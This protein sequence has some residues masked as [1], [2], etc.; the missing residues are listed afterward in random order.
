MQTDDLIA[1]LSGELVP[2][3]RGAVLRP[4]MLGL[5]AGVAAS[6]L[7]LLA[8]LHLR[9]DLA[10]SMAGPDFWIKFTYSVALMLL[11]LWLVERMSR[12]GARAS[13]PGW[14]LSI[15]V[16]L[17]ALAA[18]LQM[19]APGADPQALMMGHTARHCSAVILMLSVPIFAGVFWAMRRLA[20]TELTMAGAGAGFLSGAA[21][22]AVY[23][24]HCPEAAAPF[25][26][27]WYTLAIL[28]A[29]AIGAVIGRWALRW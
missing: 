18:V 5:V 21:S 20:P 26:L 22:A 24:L 14:M 3:R 9:A 12:P 2:S 28:V 6:F 13:R 7:A 10:R 29:A 27:I 23:C 1:A 17:L 15:P 25:I 16:A 19:S 8:T 11:G 4:L